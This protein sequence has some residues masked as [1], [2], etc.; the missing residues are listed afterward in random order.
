[1]KFAEKVT[2]LRTK[3]NM[4]QAELGQALNLSKQ[5]V[6][7]WESGAGMPDIAI[8]LPLSKILDCSV[9]VLLDDN[10]SLEPE[11]EPT[12]EI[13]VDKR[14][15]TY[16]ELA[17]RRKRPAIIIVSIAAIFLIAGLIGLIASQDWILKII[18]IIV[19]CIGFMIALAAL[20]PLAIV[21]NHY[22]FEGHEI[23]AYAGATEHYLIVD[24]LVEDYLQ[25][26]FV[27]KDRILKA[28]IDEHQITMSITWTN[29][30]T[31]KIDDQIVFPIK[32]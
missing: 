11:Q 26:E 32:K 18:F 3:Q 17:N 6:Q 9:D 12:S 28:K 1:M 5:A 21:L 2:I 30:V 14:K 27:I 22:E 29:N 25:A 15:I 13:K 16:K 10:K 20:A 24:E 8:M 19:L 31:V 4:S 23:I 7:K